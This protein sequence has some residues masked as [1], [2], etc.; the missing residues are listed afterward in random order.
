M[1]KSTRSDVL[2]ELQ[3]RVD[4]D[5]PEKEIFENCILKIDEDI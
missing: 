2:N 3:K 5:W 1:G 4:E